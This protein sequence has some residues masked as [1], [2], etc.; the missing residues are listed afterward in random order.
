MWYLLCNNNKYNYY[1]MSQIRKLRHVEV[2][3]LDQSHA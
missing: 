2:K 1:Y 3:Q